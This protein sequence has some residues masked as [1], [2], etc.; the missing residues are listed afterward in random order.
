[1]LG[2]IADL[3]P[4]GIPWYNIQKYRFG[5]YLHDPWN[6]FD[7]SRI[8]AFIMFS[9]CVVEIE[10]RVVGLSPCSWMIA[11]DCSCLHPLVILEWARS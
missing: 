7:L 11:D 4:D 8:F 10:V 9:A 3:K 5:E 6:W 2:E 1:M